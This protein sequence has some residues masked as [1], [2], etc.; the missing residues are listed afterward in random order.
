[1]DKEK[2]RFTSPLKAY[3]AG[4]SYE[5]TEEEKEQAEKDFDKWVEECLKKKNKN[6]KSE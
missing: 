1:M 5:L 6:D 4:I 3:P 2:N